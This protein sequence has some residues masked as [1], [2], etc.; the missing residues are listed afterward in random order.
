[1]YMANEHSRNK[2]FVANRVATIRDATE[3]SQ[4]NYIHSKSNP[5]DD[6]TRGQNAN[7]WMDNKQWLNGPDILWKEKEQ[8][9]RCLVN[10]KETIPISQDDPEVNKTH[11]VNAICT[12]EENATQNTVYSVIFSYWA[13]ALPFIC[14]G[15]PE[16]GASRLFD[17]FHGPAGTLQQ[18]WSSWL[19][20]RIP[21]QA[22]SCTAPTVKLTTVFWGFSELL[23]YNNLHS[24]TGNAFFPYLWWQGPKIFV[25]FQNSLPMEAKHWWQTNFIV[26]LLPVVHKA[27]LYSAF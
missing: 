12:K 22:A 3:L 27:E 4:W 19:Y 1:M 18:Q 9:Q 26:A 6:A 15:S 25:A 17:A 21:Q 13:L 8:Q 24:F 10:F 16:L 2:T 20:T 11:T 5:A 14:F 7:K 23:W